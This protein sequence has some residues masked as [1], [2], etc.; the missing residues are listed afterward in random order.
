MHWRRRISVG[1]D[2]DFSAFKRIRGAKTAPYGMPVSPDDFRL[3]QVGFARLIGNDIDYLMCKYEI[4]LGRKSKN[5]KLDV[6]LGDTMSLS[7]T[8][9]KISYNFEQSKLKA[10]RYPFIWKQGL[11]FWKTS[12]PT[13]L[14]HILLLFS[15]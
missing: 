1:I 8:H 3:Q 14:S 12:F 7:R 13:A 10:P 2:L 5:T 4:T 11:F 9:A 6:V 15:L